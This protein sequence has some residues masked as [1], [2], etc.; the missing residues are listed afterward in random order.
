MRGDPLKSIASMIS[1]KGSLQKMRVQWGDVIQY[2]LPVGRTHLPLNA[3]MGE[4]LRLKFT[5][6]ISCIHCDR[7]ITKT[8]NQGYCF[9]CFRQLAACDLCILKPELCH[10]FKGT[11]REPTWGEAHCMQP[12]IVYLAN[13]GDLKIG[14]T[15]GSQIPTRWIDQGAQ[16]ALPILRTS[17]RQIAGFVEAAFK[18]I[19]SDQT[20]WRKMLAGKAEFIDLTKKRDWIFNEKK[21]II[22]SVRSQ[23]KAEDVE[24]LED[25]NEIEI[26]YPVQS[27]PSKIQ[28]L[29]LDKEGEIGGKLV[30]MKGQYLIFDTGVINIRKFAG[31]EVMVSL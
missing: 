4:Q 6:F 14:L 13:T 17:R 22:E 11:C 19:I 12:H 5:G 24:L 16:Q 26:N 18:K 29:S 28:S 25:E 3:L 21:D 20:Q 8:F 30:G 2:E 7:K 31:Y 9:P 27:Y 15:R 23:F 10:Y 1:L